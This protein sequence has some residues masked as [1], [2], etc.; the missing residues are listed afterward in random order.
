MPDTRA[1]LF[2]Y[3]IDSSVLQSLHEYSVSGP[4]EPKEEICHLSTLTH[5]PVGMK[6]E[7][8]RFLKDLP[9]PSRS[10]DKKEFSREFGARPITFPVVLFKRGTELLVLARTEEI[11]RCQA[12]ADLI[13]LVQERLAQV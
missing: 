6:K 9:F 8:K 1:V 5:S 7:W 2:V 11:A 3:N 4:A 12:L 10:M 13:T